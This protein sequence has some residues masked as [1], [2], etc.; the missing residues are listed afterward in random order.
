M[1]AIRRRQ[2]HARQVILASGKPPAPGG[3]KVF[4]ELARRI[5][6]GSSVVFL[7][8]ATLIDGDAATE[9]YPYHLRWAPFPAAERPSLVWTP[10][11]YFRADHWAKNHPIFA[12]LP[13][14]G[15]MD[16]RFYREIIHGRVLRD[17]PLTDEAVCG[18]VYASG[19]GFAADLIVSVHRLGAGRFIL[20][21]LRIRDNLGAVP[22]AERLLRN[23]LNHAAQTTA[24][25]A[26]ALPAGF[27]DQL[28]TWFGAGAAPPG[29]L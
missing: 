1:E 27:N 5:A 6:T 10:S 20:N 16:Y 3:S 25:P 24:E 28:A 11:W 8:A 23:L 9:Q 13:S 12:G 19:P 2:P 26:C 15:V 18:A 4:A 7:T 29:N 17:V 14:G 22:A 21:T